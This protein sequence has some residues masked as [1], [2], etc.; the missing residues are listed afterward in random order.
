MTVFDSWGWVIENT[1][2]SPWSLRLYTRGETRCYG[3]RIHKEPCGE[4]LHSLLMA[5]TNLAATW[6]SH[7]GSRSSI[8]SHIFRWLQPHLLSWVQT[9]EGPWAM[10]TQLCCSEFLTHSTVR[11][12]NVCCLKPSHL[13]VICYTA[14]DSESPVL[15][16]GYRCWNCWSHCLC[17][18]DASASSPTKVRQTRVHTIG[19]SV[20]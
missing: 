7:L 8:P 10:A 9:P 13:G 17:E 19:Y 12:R 2:A 3:L 4:E 11:E 20:T 6:V 5:S 1:E 14:T 16:M 15:G 18:L